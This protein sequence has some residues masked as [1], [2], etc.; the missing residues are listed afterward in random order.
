MICDHFQIYWDYFTEPTDEDKAANQK[1]Q[2]LK[3]AK[4][5]ESREKKKVNRTFLNIL[6]LMSYFILLT[7]LSN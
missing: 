1:L 5:K 3:A 7:N 2:A 4:D 6:N